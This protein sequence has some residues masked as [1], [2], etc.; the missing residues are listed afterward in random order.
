MVNP[1]IVT[2]DGRSPRLAGLAQW[3]C[4]GFVILS[5]PFRRVPIGPKTS[6]IIWLFRSR[7]R[8]LSVL[9]PSRATEFGSKFGSRRSPG[10]L[11][12][13]LETAGRDRRDTHL[14]PPVFTHSRSD[15][16]RRPAIPTE[17]VAGVSLASPAGGQ[18]QGEKSNP[19]RKSTGWSALR[20]CRSDTYKPDR[21]PRCKEVFCRLQG[22][23]RG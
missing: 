16:P 5:R 9:V 10:V 13:P 21:A 11:P 8:P 3:Q 23:E 19:H 12:P 6:R 1:R 17:E 15:Q 18:N 7:N 20:S 2:P 14:S 22:A 4:S